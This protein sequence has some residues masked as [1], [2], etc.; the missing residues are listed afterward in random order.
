[1]CANDDTLQFKFS[2]NQESYAD[3]K[4]IG[5]TQL[6]VPTLIKRHGN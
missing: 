4:Y 6:Y 1:M 2:K 5:T 3:G